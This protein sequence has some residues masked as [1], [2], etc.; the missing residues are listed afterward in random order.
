MIKMM[1]RMR[2]TIPEPTIHLFL[3]ILLDIVVTGQHS[4]PLVNSS[5]HTPKL[6]HKSQSVSFFLNDLM[7]DTK[8]KPEK[9]FD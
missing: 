2:A 9:V 1:A 6:L 3:V 5:I 4:L 8:T 7:I